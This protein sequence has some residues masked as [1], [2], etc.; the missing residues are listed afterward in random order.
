MP[1]SSPTEVPG[2]AWSDITGGAMRHRSQSQNHWRNR[3]ERLSQRSV[4]QS[5]LN[6][7]DEIYRPIAIG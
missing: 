1:G 6:E 7:S 2:K 4:G 5:A 3:V